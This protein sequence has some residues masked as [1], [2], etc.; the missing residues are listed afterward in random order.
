MMRLEGTGSIRFRLAPARRKKLTR[1][2]V[3]TLAACGLILLAAGVAHV[4]RPNNDAEA[5]AATPAVPPPPAPSAAIA[6]PAQAP[7]PPAAAAPAPADTPTTGTLRLQRPA[8]PGKVWLD[9]DK[10]SAASAS[11]ACGK[12]QLKIGPHGKP[13]TVDIPCGGELKV[14]R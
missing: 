14:S 9:G 3:A 8:A 5:Y 13:R 2:V 11:V 6:P 4:L 1:I 7:A 12:H 10:I